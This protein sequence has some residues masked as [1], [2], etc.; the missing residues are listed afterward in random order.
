MFLNYERKKF[1][2]IGPRGWRTSCLAKTAA[3]PSTVRARCGN[4]STRYKLV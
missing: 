1:Y 2:N 3:R 4:T